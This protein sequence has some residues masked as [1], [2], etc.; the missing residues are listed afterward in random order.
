M[1]PSLSATYTNILVFAFLL[2]MSGFFSSSEVVFFGA[3]RL[4]LKLKRGRIYRLL[5]RLLEKKHKLLLSILIGN[6]MV[7]VLI[8]SY[9]TKLFVSTL[10]SKGAGL[11]VFF[12]SL[13]I[14]I[15]GEVLPKNLVYPFST[16]LATFYA[17]P[18]YLIHLLLTP[19][20][21]PLEFFTHRVFGDEKDITKQ[22]NYED[23]FWEIFEMAHAQGA[24][25]DEDRLTAERVLSLG[26]VLVKEVMVPKPDM[27]TLE[28]ELTV[29]QAI[30]QILSR[31][32]SRIPLYRENPDN[33]TG[34][35]YVKDMVPFDLFKDK[36]LKDFKKPALFVPEVQTLD[37]LLKELRSENKQMAVVV[38]EHGEVVGLITLYD[39]MEY[40]LGRLPETWEGGISR[41]S[42][43]VYRIEGWVD[44]E[45]LSRE[46][47]IQLPEEYEYDTV[48]GFVMFTLGHVPE[49]GDEFEY[50]G[51]K[52][53]IEKMDGNRVISV[54]AVNM[55][56][57]A[58]S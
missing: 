32:H 7:N 49:E 3:N 54:Y 8:S 5:H 11:A 46:L 42:R 19:L 40:C 10:G 57:E 13:L 47:K 52:F 21:K 50:E 6:E 1:E 14:F 16:R 45:E 43:D 33:I 18:F 20:R 39:I 56:K 44:V 36:R 41:I 23:L 15:F 26:E 25:D 37:K 29:E 4:L 34:I 30:S 28:E 51:Y 27:F 55:S 2:Y 48:G 24:F 38:G 58:V 35:L 17:L 53:R 22:P 12:S 9:S 31:K